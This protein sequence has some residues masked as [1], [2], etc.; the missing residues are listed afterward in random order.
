MLSPGHQR[1]R[2]HAA[3]GLAAA[4][5]TAC[6]KI[7]LPPGAPPDLT[8]P[9]LVSVFPDSLAVLPGFNGEVVFRFNEVISEGS[10]PSQGT[11]TGDLERLVLLSPTTRPAEVRWRR[12]RITVRPR[13]GWKPNRVYR[14]ELLPGASDLRNNRSTGGS[15]IVTFTTGSPRPS[16]TL[17]GAAWDWLTGRAS[18]AALIE[19][20]HTSDSLVY[21]ALA[22]SSGG[23][24][25]GPLPDGPY[26]VYA[27]MDQ[28]RNGVRDPREAFDTVRVAA[29]RANVGTLWMFPHD[30]IGPRIQSITMLDSASATITFSQ[31][32]DPTRVIGRTGVSVRLLPDSTPV[33]VLS[34][35]SPAADDSAFGRRPADSL[36]RPARDTAMGRS[37]RDSAEGRRGRDTTAKAVPKQV[38]AVARPDTIPRRPA[39]SERLV[40]RVAG[41]WKPG[42]RYTVLI[43]GVRNLNGVAADAVGVLAVAAPAPATGADST[44]RRV[45]PAPDS[46]AVRTKPR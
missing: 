45:R 39:V 5:I 40:L 24:Q 4:A 38:P 17:I 46:G 20:V 37:V 33:A 8:P 28:N 16:L 23:F 15:R 10:S 26:L 14:V 21:R 6:A 12:D 7:E 30:T 2:S 13:E 11:G 36:A 22:D 35:L 43:R 44:G 19:A 29:G 27:A 32:I 3:L 1:F 31:A 9:Q 18:P 25:L 42:G 34:I 41:K